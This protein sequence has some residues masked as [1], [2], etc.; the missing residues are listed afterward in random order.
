MSRAPFNVLVIPY[1]QTGESISYCIFKRENMNIWQFVAGGGE[2]TEP[3]LLAAM[4]ETMEEAG[5]QSEKYIQ[6]TSMCHVPVNCFSDEA[7]KAWG[8]DVFVIPVYSF[9]VQCDADTVI[10]LSDEHLE[11]RWCSYEAANAL[12]HFD[13]DKTALYELNERIQRHAL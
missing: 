8:D 1:R 9:G 6:L 5:I 7:R 12:L 2:D 3:P 13:L 11:Y 10:A 4:R